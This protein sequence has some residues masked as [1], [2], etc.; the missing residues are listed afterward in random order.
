MTMR[1]VVLIVG[2]MVTACGASRPAPCEVARAIRTG[3]RTVEE[4][5]RIAEGV[6]CGAEE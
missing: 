4:A 1:V 3:A 5:A 6:A 2:V